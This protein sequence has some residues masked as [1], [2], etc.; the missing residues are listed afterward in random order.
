MFADVFVCFCPLVL[1]K[2]GIFLQQTKY[3]II[4]RTTQSQ[5]PRF[6]K[7]HN[8]LRD[9]DAVAP[10]ILKPQGDKKIFRKNWER[11]IQ[12]IGACPGAD[13]IL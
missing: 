8:T 3:D 6:C 7:T 9:I 11:L 12:K 2:L 10:C 1:K 13:L 5:L 4:I